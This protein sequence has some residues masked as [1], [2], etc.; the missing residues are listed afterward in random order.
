MH[1]NIFFIF[2]FVGFPQIISDVVDKNNV[3][4]IWEKPFDGECRVTKY[5]VYYREIERTLGSGWKAVIVSKHKLNTTVQLTCHRMYEV[6]ITAWTSYG[7]TPRDQSRVKRV[8]TLGGN[9][10]KVGFST[11]IAAI[12]STHIGRELLFIRQQIMKPQTTDKPPI[13]IGLSIVEIYFDRL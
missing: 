3:T 8:L 10:F 5:T 1:K 4:V 9:D 13:P 6:E 12:F 7:E 11:Y 2:Y